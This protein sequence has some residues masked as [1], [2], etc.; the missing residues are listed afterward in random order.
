MIE[1]FISLDT[2]ADSLSPETVA[3]LENFRSVFDKP[4]ATMTYERDQEIEYDD[5]VADLKLLRGLFGEP[6]ERRHDLVVSA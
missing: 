3:F 4:G 6:Q 2:H 5:I 1:P